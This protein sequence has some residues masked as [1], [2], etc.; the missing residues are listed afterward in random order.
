MTSKKVTICK[1]GNTIVL[2]P[3]TDKIFEI[4]EPKLSFVEHVKLQGWEAKKR[5]D[6]GLSVHKMINHSLFDLDH[7]KRI[8]T[9]YGFWKLIRDTL[10]QAGYTVDMVDLS[11]PSD[12]SR[13]QP[14]MENIARYK[15]RD[16][17]PE[18]LRK[19]MTH[20]CG[21]FD[22]PP[23][24]GK[25]FMI[26]LIASVYP[27]A[28]IDVV[29]RRVPV[30]R[31]RIYPELVQ[32]VGDVGI[33]GGGKSQRNRRVMCYTVGSMGHSPAT[34]DIL[35]GD[36]CH[37]LAADCSAAQLVRWQ[38]SRNYGLSA[39][40]DLRFDNKDLRMHGVFG[41]IIFSVDY[42]QA[43]DS[44]MVVPIEVNWSVVAMDYN[45]CRD[46]ESD[47]EKKRYGIWQN[48][49]RN[50]IIA[51]DARKYDENTQVLITVDTIAHAMRL[52]RLLPEFTLVYADKGLSEDDRRKYV[53]QGCCS[54]SEP[55][56][57]LERRMALTKA[58]ES[59]KL[60]KA[61]CTTVWNVGV[62]FNSLAVLIRAGAGG[63]AIN[64]I[65]IPGR[66]SRIAEGKTHGI[67]HDY[68]DKFDGKFNFQ[69]KARVKSYQTNRWKQNFPRPGLEQEYL[70]KDA[71]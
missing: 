19:V 63:S 68:L 67:V 57:T 71:K 46:I 28:R 58:F 7:K 32:M 34:A 18:F 48:D 53:N 6:K 36:E 62:S 5:R 59:G 65:Q 31:D 23:G 55:I 20:S 30:L 12:S 54:D 45:P 8:A 42:Q 44:K 24:F 25:S 43:A 10:R 52:K 49:V 13:L 29:T 1:S 21:R 11:P 16:N 35:I 4:L 2:D 61:I 38:N 9:M 33:V 15:L 41:P 26:G 22:C 14:A 3:T 66:V 51:D 56:M 50:Q 60:K 40:H 47:V 69:S 70:K 64:D 27:K 39:S 37:E 17:Q